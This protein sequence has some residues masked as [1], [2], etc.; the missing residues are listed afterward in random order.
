MKPCT[1]SAQHTPPSLHP[2]P[3]S[4]AS[5]AAIKSMGQL[6]YTHS[7][8]LFVCVWDN[9]SDQMTT[10]TATAYVSFYDTYTVQKQWTDSN[11]S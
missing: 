1:N 4:I 11:P 6:T 8:L 2:P 9:K 3:G 5:G 7:R 10:S